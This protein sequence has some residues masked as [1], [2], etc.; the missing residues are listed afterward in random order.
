M[1][2]LPIRLLLLVLLGLRVV[3]CSG[4]RPPASTAPARTTADARPLGPT[5]APDD[6]AYAAAL[7]QEDRLLRQ[8]TVR[9]APNEADTTFLKRMFPAS[10]L[11]SRGVVTYAWHPSAFGKQLFFSYRGREDNEGG[12]N[13]YV[14]DPFQANAYAVH[15]LPLPSMGD[16][17]DLD[18]LFFLDVNQDG[19]KEL[20]TL[21]SCLLKG[22]EKNE[23]G[24]VV[25]GS[26]YHYQTLIFQYVDA[27]TTGRPQYRLDPTLRPYLDELPTAADVR[28]LLARHHAQR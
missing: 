21:L 23:A 18:A 5:P 19:R 4:Q 10:F 11:P 13:L 3:V 27:A 26:S 14:L 24:E 22:S 6:S 16:L 15:V 28:R 7:R 12:T 8:G 25:Y 20:L 2:P 9:R 17:T 1:F